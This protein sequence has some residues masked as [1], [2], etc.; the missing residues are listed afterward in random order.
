MPLP[1]P[2]A[3]GLISSGI[4][5]L[6]RRRGSAPRPTGRRRRSHAATGTPS[7]RRAVA[8]RPCR[9]SPGSP[10]AA[11]RS[12]G[13]PAAMTAS[14]K[15]AF[16]ARNP[17]PGWTASA[18]AA[19]AAATTAS[20]SRRSSASGPVGRWRLTARM[21][22]RS[23]VRVIRAAIS[24]RLAMKTRPDGG[25]ASRSRRIR[26]SR[27]RQS[28]Q[29]R[30]ASGRRRAVPAVAAGDPA[31]HRPGR[32]PES[33]ATSL[34]LSSSA[35]VARVSHMP[36][37]DAIVDSDDL[38]R[39]RPDRACLTPRRPMPRRPR[40]RDAFCEPRSVMPQATSMAVIGPIDPGGSSHVAGRRV[41]RPSAGSAPAGGGGQPRS[42]ARYS[43]MRWTQTDWIACGL[44]DPGML[45]P[46]SVDREPAVRNRELETGERAGEQAR[47]GGPAAGRREHVAMD[48]TVDV[49]D[50][51]AAAETG[52]RSFRRH[53][54]GRHPGG[55]ALLVEGA[56][57]P[58][59]PR[60]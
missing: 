47:V 17:K 34:G 9:P 58:P 27:T 14:A 49:G 5:D 56:R 31:L 6:L 55:R 44:G 35:I 20:T 4:A 26:R 53:S 16:S 1:P 2:P 42:S 3:A 33:L 21:P 28:R 36:R 40:R 15:S 19:R 22:S 8:R 54:I 50:E 30:H 39:G 25:A 59:A 10:P 18:P 29:T 13:C 24:P 41:D 48:G 45:R 23:H 7:R 57:S 46:R 32:R 43:V 52:D 12:S 37:S 51:G 38:V 11:G 60:R